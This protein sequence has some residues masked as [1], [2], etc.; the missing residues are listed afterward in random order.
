MTMFSGFSNMFLLLWKNWILK[1]RKLLGLTL[2][3]LIPLVLIFLFSYL[4]T[5]TPNV[6]VPAGWSSTTANNSGCKND[7]TG[8]YFLLYHIIF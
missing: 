4:K 6:D 8:F 2:E 3:M 1:R 7:C 5:L